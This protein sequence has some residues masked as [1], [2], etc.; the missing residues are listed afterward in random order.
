MHDPGELPKRGDDG[1][2]YWSDGTQ[3]T[4]EEFKSITGQAE[5][6][7]PT[8]S[9]VVT[10]VTGTTDLTGAA[11]TDLGSAPGA[12]LDT[13]QADVQRGNMEQLINAL[14]Q[15]ATTGN[16]AWQASF[17]RGV[18]QAMGNASST[19]QAEQ[20]MARSGSAGAMRNIANAQGAVGQ[21]AV[22]QEQ[23]LRQQSMNAAQDQL[24]QLESGLGAG[25]I[26]QAGAAAAAAQGAREA[27]A[28][29]EATARANNIAL[30]G[31]IAQAVP[32]VGQGIGSLFTSG[33]SYSDGGRVPGRP[34]TFGD[35]EKNDTVPAMLSPGEIVVPRSRASDPEAAAKFARMVAMRHGQHMADGG[36]AGWKPDD[37]DP[38]A[39]GPNFLGGTTEA[40]SIQNGGLL[41]AAPYA[42]TR[43]QMDTL[44]GQFGE[45]ARGQG[46][47]ADVMA[48]QQ[49]DSQMANALAAQNGRQAAA[50]TTQ[51]AGRQGS[52]VAEVQGARRGNEQAAGQQALG[53]QLTDRRQQELAL[54]QAQ[55]QAE[56]RNSMINAGVS[57]QNQA[58]IR[59]ILGGAGQAATGLAGA[60]SKGGGGGP[61]AASADDLS[62]LSSNPYPEFDEGPGGG[63][64]TEG[65]D[66]TPGGTE[67]ANPYAR[68]GRIPGYAD[69]GAVERLVA[70]INKGRRAKGREESAPIHATDAEM[71]EARTNPFASERF[72]MLSPQGWGMGVDVSADPWAVRPLAQAPSRAPSAAIDKFGRTVMRNDVG[73]VTDI[74]LAQRPDMQLPPL[75][76]NLGPG[77]PRGA[78]LP[79]V[80]APQRRPHGTHHAE[81][82]TDADLG[83]LEVQRAHGGSIPG[84]A[85][86]G[87]AT[88]PRWLN[89]PAGEV[90]TQGLPLTD[91]AA[92]RDAYLASLGMGDIEPRRD[93]GPVVA[94]IDERYPPPAGGYTSSTPLTS[95]EQEI[96]SQAANPPTAEAVDVQRGLQARA[97]RELLGIKR[98]PAPAGDSQQTPGAMPDTGQPTVV[99]ARGVAP[100]PDSDLAD[101]RAGEKDEQAALR[102]QAQAQQQATQANVQ[103]LIANDTAIKA[104]DAAHVQRQQVAAQR[105]DAAM[106]RYQGAQDEMARIDTTVDPGRYWASRSTGGK[107]AGIIG[108][109][110]GALGTGPDGI[111][112]AAAMMD[113]AID[114]DL[115]AQKA[116]HELRL[117]KG[118]QR[119]QGAQTYYSMA[120]DALGDETAATSAAHG[121]ALEAAARQAEITATKVNDPMQRAKLQRVAAAARQAA[122][123]KTV[124][125]R[126]ELES[127][128]AAMIHAQ[129]ARA[130]AGQKAGGLT[131]ER[132][133]A[134][135]DVESATRNIRDNLAKAKAIVEKSGTFEMTGTDQVELERALSMVATDSAR[136][137]DPGSTVRE[138]EL[139]VAKKEIG[140]KGGEL[141][142]RNNTAQKLLDSFE[143]SIEDRRRNAYRARGLEAPK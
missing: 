48:Q 54:A 29:Q 34:R 36:Y 38:T 141:L 131:G 103:Q 83:D 136:L 2:W 89:L 97:D 129:A 60:L 8:D 132:Q 45:R 79:P 127:A 39:L 130:A 69:G 31:G 92:S 88:D 117:R 40:P 25:D 110:L 30:V 100:R 55:Q 52:A 113:K 94:A 14:Q 19:G 86:G 49:S 44:G 133:K 106:K 57:L 116:G 12:S 13:T 99:A 42:Q 78:R 35:N 71:A 109:V 7:A 33:P 43:G 18:Q 1:N 80:G 26:N 76:I 37:S 32:L 119:V 138:G 90:P 9:H 126:T 104:S 22:G 102:A 63:L 4:P 65:G 105:S 84:Y 122:G 87:V 96:S 108:L 66:P 50:N 11:S 72:N 128:G 114:R 27:K 62:A 111:N 58:A 17:N 41:D 64:K 95:V 24:S 125:A 101:I 143:K 137:K 140:L 142:L 93:S 107:I 85:D 59:S 56:W 3:V 124:K 23:A 6:N 75:A 112:R 10:G 118:A 67:W 61:Y 115:E 51:Q 77:G 139:E 120:R 68:G 16:G 91:P 121:A 47:I 70:A 28:S 46:S 135:D 81:A 123:E 21:R 73:D 134:I 74:A 98:G 5:G 20:N 15:Q 82:F 53:R